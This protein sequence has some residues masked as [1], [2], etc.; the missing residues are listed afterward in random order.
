MTDLQEY[1]E[2]E[3]GKSPFRLYQEM[4]S[5]ST[6]RTIAA[7]MEISEKTLRRWRIGWG[8]PLCSQ[9][10]SD[11]RVFDEF[12]GSECPTDVSARSLGYR[13]AGHAVRCM[14]NE[15]LTNNQMAK[16]LSCCVMTILRYKPKELKRE[17]D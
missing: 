17:Y 14:T 9:A 5:H 10:F 16:E 1:I 7:T 8:E 12:S 2:Q 6:F 4:R 13:D 3:F 11:D 15:D